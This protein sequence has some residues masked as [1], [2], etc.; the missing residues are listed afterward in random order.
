[1]RARPNL[2]APRLGVH[3]LRAVLSNMVSQ[4]EID[5]AHALRGGR[6]RQCCLAAGLI[7]NRGRRAVLRLDGISSV[8][9]HSHFRRVLVLQP[10][11][12]NLVRDVCICREAAWSTANKSTSVGQS[13]IA[14]S[15][16][17]NAGSGC[18]DAS[19]RVSSF[20]QTPSLKR[21]VRSSRSMARRVAREHPQPFCSSQPTVRG[22]AGHE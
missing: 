18:D 8:F 19:S 20:R 2:S 22:V 15:V 12:G 4:F 9:M 10:I 6:S 5:C 7:Q 13:L 21:A 3:A 14:S 17:C 1:M 11:C 16:R